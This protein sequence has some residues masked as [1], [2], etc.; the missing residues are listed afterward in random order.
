MID[1]NSTKL[2]VIG[3][4]KKLRFESSMAINKKLITSVPF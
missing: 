4:C 2:L 1:S 3:I